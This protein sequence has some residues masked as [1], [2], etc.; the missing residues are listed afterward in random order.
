[1]PSAKTAATPSFC[2]NFIC[3]LMTMVIGSEMMIASEMMLTTLDQQKLH[4]DGLF[5]AY[6]EWLSSN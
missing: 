4:A 3:S 5:L 1:M 2:F 6:R